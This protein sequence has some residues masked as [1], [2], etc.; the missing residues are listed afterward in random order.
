MQRDRRGGMKVVADDEVG[1]AI[2]RE[3]PH[4]R[5]LA[6]P[7]T[8]Y[9]GSRWILARGIKLISAGTTVGW[10]ISKASSPSTLQLGNYRSTPMVVRGA[11]GKT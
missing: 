4:R 11:E 9:E 8:E 2:H 7:R 3:A 6:N 5:R 10:L 1:T